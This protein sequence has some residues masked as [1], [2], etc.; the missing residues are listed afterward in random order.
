MKTKG[1]NRVTRE[2]MRADKDKLKLFGNLAKPPMSTIQRLVYS[3]MVFLR[4]EFDSHEDLIKADLCSLEMA[5][6]IGNLRFDH[7]TLESVLAI[8][9]VY[10][11]QKYL[12]KLKENLLSQMS[13]KELS[14]VRYNTDMDSNEELAMFATVDV[15]ISVMEG[16]AIFGD[17]K[18]VSDFSREITSSFHE[19]YP[20]RKKE[21]QLLKSA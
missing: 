2:R 14:V 10:L 18:T 6:K 17:N 16:K 19:I 8:V 11:G 15:L 12:R 4:N 9:D 21:A 3:S 5:S 13:E 1:L 20:F 7:T